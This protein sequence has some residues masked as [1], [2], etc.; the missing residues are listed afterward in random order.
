[1]VAPDIKNIF[2]ALLLV[3]LTFCGGAYAQVTLNLAAGWNLVG[4]SVNAPLPVAAT[5][6]NQPVSTVWK[7]ENFGTN[8][9]ITY[10]AW[11]FYTPSLPD[12]GQTYAASKGY[13]FLTTINGGEGFWVYAK[14]AVTTVPLPAGVAVT[15]AGFQNTPAPPY[16][17][18]TGWSLISVGDSPT[19]LL[20]DIGLNPSAVAPIPVNLTSLWA[21][22]TLTGNWYFYAPS[23]DANNTLAVYTNSKNYLNFGT[24]ALAPTTGFWVNMPSVNG[25][26]ITAQAITGTVATD[27]AVYPATVTIEDSKGAI[28]SGPTSPTGTYSIVVSGMTPPF[29]LRTTSAALPLP[30]Y[31]VLPAMP[32]SN[33]ANVNITPVTTLVMYQLNGSS[34]PVSMYAGTGFKAITAAAIAAAEAVV[35]DN[36]SSYFTNNGNAG[37][38][39]AL[40]AVPTAFDMM[41]GSFTAGSPTDAYANLLI[42]TG[43]LIGYPTGGFAFGS[44]TM[45]LV[46]GDINALDMYW[47]GSSSAV[48]VAS[49]IA[50]GTASGGV[51]ISA[52]NSSVVVVNSGGNAPAGIPFSFTGGYNYTMLA[53]PTY[54]AGQ[55]T[56]QLAQLADNQ[57]APP[58]GEGLLGV[59]DYAGAG[60]LDVYVIASNGDAIPSGTRPWASGIAGSANYSAVTT[61]STSASF[62]IQV[63]GFGA[64]P[65]NDVRLDIPSVTLGNGQVMTLA[66]TPTTGG[67]LVDGLLILQQEQNPIGGQQVVTPYKNGSARVRIAASFAAIGNAPITA[68]TANG[69]S[70][71]AA[72]LSSGS[73]GPYVVVPLT[74]G[75]AATPQT[76]APAGAQALPVTLNGHAVSISGSCAIATATATPGQD[77]TL[78]VTGSAAAPQY[79]TIADDNTLAP[80][81]YAKL[82]L[83]DGVN[84]YAG[85]FTLT[86]GGAYQ[87]SASFGA[88]STALDVLIPS[89]SLSVS[90]ATSNS[91]LGSPALQVL[92]VY[93]VFMLGDSTS[94]A[95]AVLSAD[96]TYGAGGG[97]G[98]S[99]LGGVAAADGAPIEGAT[100]NVVCA[101]GASLSA[102]TG[103]GGAWQ[104]TL[105]GLALPCA[106]EVSGGTI[107]SAPNTTS[108]YSIATAAGTMNISPLTSLIVANLAGEDPGAW[109]AALTPATLGGIT[110]QQVTTAFNNVVAALSGLTQLGNNNPITTPFV[111]T[112]GNVSADMLAALSQAI[113]N[114]NFSYA[115]LLS[116]M[117]SASPSVAAS[118]NSS[119]IAAYDTNTQSGAAG[120]QTI[121]VAPSGPSVAAGL[122]QQFTASGKYLDGTS[123]DI[124]SVVSWSSGNTAVATVNTSSGLASAAKTAAGNSATIT[125]TSG[126][127]TGSATLG[128]TLG[129]LQSISVA[130]VN[131]SVAAG[132]T[133]QFTATGNYSDGTTQALTSGVTWSSGNTAVATVNA[134][135]GLA[136]AAKTAAGGSATIKAVYGAFSASTTLSVTLAILQSISVTPTNPSV[137][138]GFTQQFAAT[139]INSDGTAQSL[140]GSAT[141]ASGNPGVATVNSS[142]L[143]TGVAGGS[144]SITA[145]Y[146]GFSGNATLTVAALQSIS[147]TPAAP[148]VVAG[149]TLQFSATGNYSGGITQPFTSV[150]TW[151]SGNTGIATVSTSGLATGVAAGSATI[152]ATSGAVSG[153]VTLSV[154]QNVLNVL[155]LTVDG[156]PAGLGYTDANI[157]FV[158]VTICV[159]GTSTCQT[160]DHVL[161]DTGSSGLRIVS[162]VLNG[163]M[164]SLPQETV[165][166]S[167]LAECL[168]YVS[169]SNWGAVRTADV[170]L[171]GA[172]AGS[173]PIHIIG[174]AAF[175]SIPASCPAPVQD[176]VSAFGAN[177]II[178]VST[179]LQDCGLACAPGYGPVPG[180]Y[181][182]CP[183]G[184]CSPVSVPLAEQV[185]NPVS[186]LPAGYN[187]GV[188]LQLPGVPAGGSLTVSGSLILGVGTESNNTLGSAK[189]YD[190]DPNTGNFSTTFNG[191][192]YYDA[193]FLDSGSNGYFFYSGLS[194]CGSRSYA[195]GF[196]CPK[197]TQSLSATNSG[198]SNGNSATASFS[199]A[200]ANNL[201][202]GAN[203]AFSNL[204]GSGI[205]SSFDWG[206]PFFFGRTVYNVFDGQSAIYGAGPY[207]A[208]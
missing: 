80:A 90:P 106:V 27:S 67:V 117:A 39:S 41:Y 146:G 45:R 169:S 92:G 199:V 113:S 55:E 181:Y 60:S 167:A 94:A 104:V 96:H 22:D 132:L 124:T 138:A 40:A 192:S 177:G 59:A 24:G 123:A 195:P 161:L 111:P 188:V 184:T 63:T 152:T 153:S 182:T 105:A 206:L 141:W 65:N 193:A 112:P 116:A 125:A 135:S 49:S 207:V 151:S 102:L 6:G 165:G 56:L 25:V 163:Q 145:S 78:L 58:S 9:N 29:M 176:T 83:V 93:S 21:W 5:F 13:D 139:G 28:A 72:S 168:Q 178:G 37:G 57:A 17:L 89:G 16:P 47:S 191:T 19:P 119:L 204:G 144:A 101:A 186:M 100:V 131:P 154:A 115:S 85:S 114:T 46:N 157:P 120:L 91:D 31:S 174:D 26:T 201:L 1:M 48:P 156:G 88:A 14:Q 170:Q 20:F 189:I 121:A 200:N 162:S 35:R 143:A 42:N 8:Q 179:F 86:D 149:S 108:Y 51:D 84:H 38:A 137:A 107:N 122:T 175:P 110:A 82:R 166:G 3:A 95:F 61:G 183:G 160:I 196:Y 171:G 203:T 147:V 32:A 158:S 11:A 7:W 187:N 194:P 118:F 70:I 185:P 64:G 133:Q 81:G 148:V 69:L 155:P 73:V 50:Y 198:Y 77:L 62:H 4:N 66:L 12:G 159:P 30:L 150:A 79:C 23:L 36:L 127:V 134:S 172:K 43:N 33:A 34:D 142:G 180:T 87:Q 76:G 71:L 75:A 15:T 54:T 109:F 130:P 136:S 129:V 10:P 74:G 173:V 2:L 208:Y 128:V 53:Y 205:I 126:T 99:A 44:G 197:T 103:S 190:L 202:S 98:A 18:P 140:T 68:A 164:T 52:G 97:G